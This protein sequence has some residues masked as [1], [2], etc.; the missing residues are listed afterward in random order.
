MW[1]EARDAGQHSAGTRAPPQRAI[2]SHC[3]WYSEGKSLVFIAD[4]FAGKGASVV[5]KGAP[6]SGARFLSS[7]LNMWM[8]I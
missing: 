5:T 1:M 7:P 2:P 4:N 8:S 3:P 6:A